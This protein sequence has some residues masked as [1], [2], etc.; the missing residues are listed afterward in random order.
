MSGQPEA[1]RLIDTFVSKRDLA[2]HGRATAE[3]RRLHEEN[4]RLREAN[5]KLVCAID[6]IR[7]TLM[8]SDVQDLL[9]IINRALDA[10]RGET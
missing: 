7:E 3:L 8:G 9:L 10:A 2:W 1:S 6:M 5:I 4:E